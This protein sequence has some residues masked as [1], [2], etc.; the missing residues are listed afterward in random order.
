MA[1]ERKHRM[2]GW[3]KKNWY[4]L[5]MGLMA[6]GGMIYG[7]GAHEAHQDALVINSCE[8]I[9]SLENGQDE[10]IKL[11]QKNSERIYENNKQN[12]IT[13]EALKLY[14]PNFYKEAVKNV[15]KNSP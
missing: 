12:A 8:K 15:N 14:I 6:L 13:N 7:I 4:F 1:E 10:I 11:I 9:K 2:N 3:A 5:L